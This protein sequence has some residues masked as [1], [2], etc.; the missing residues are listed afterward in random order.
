MRTAADV[1]SSV[2]TFITLGRPEES[3]N[4]EVAHNFKCENFRILKYWNDNNIMGNY[5]IA[6]TV[7]LNTASNY[8]LFYSQ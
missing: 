5:I 4:I 7:F 3:V 2:I 8:A 6:M 1:N